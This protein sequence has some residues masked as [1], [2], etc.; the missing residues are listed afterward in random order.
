MKSKDI[1]SFLETTKYKFTLAIVSSLFVY[2]F[3]LYFQPFGINNYRPDE[4]ISMVLILALLFMSMLIC[5]VILIC[6]FLVRLRL[7]KVINY[8]YLG[9]W[10]A[11]EFVIIASATFLY[12]NFIGGFHD[13][14]FTSYIKHIFS[15]SI[16][17]I[18]PFAGTLFYFKH[19]SVIKNYKEV[20][21][22]ATDTTKMHDMVLLSGDYKKDQIALPLNNIVF[23]ASEDNY[24]SLN[25]IENNQLKKYLIRS[26]LRDLEKKLDAQAIMRCNR[27]KIANLMHLESFKH[28][29]KKL[30]LKLKLVSDPITVSK[31]HQTNILSFLEKQSI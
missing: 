2:I 18:F 16:V 31:S 26:T 25:Y 19:K 14:H 11:F 20:L 9:I 12:Y 8:T 13:F 1:L 4:K 21:S 15:I 23:I 24:A 30:T 22:L 10:L 17:L 29:Q 27:S 6:E 3:F 5:L 7:F 28:H